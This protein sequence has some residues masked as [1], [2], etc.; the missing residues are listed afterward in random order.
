M[1]T[2]SAWLHGIRGLALLIVIAGHLPGIH[3]NL[4]PKL[5]LLGTSKTGVWLFFVLSAY[6]LSRPLA[7]EMMLTGRQAVSAFF[8]RRAFRILPL[9]FVVLFYLV[10]SEQMPAGSA[11]LHVAFVKGDFAFWTM[12]V[13]MAFYCLLPAFATIASLRA[14]LALLVLSVAIF[15]AS[16]P[17]ALAENSIFVVHYLVFFALGITVAYLP[18][19]RN[20]TAIAIGGL[21]IMA[22]TNVKV[23]SMTG[24]P[25]PIAF[26]PING[27]GCALLLYGATNSA[28]LQ[29][30]FSVTALAWL[31]RVSF[32]AY[33]MHYHI[34]FALEDIPVHPALKGLVVLAVVVAAATAAHFSVE[35]PMND[36]GHWLARRTQQR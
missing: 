15:L 28:V 5:D 2:E 35:R 10:Q 19:P 34:L 21:C 27:A 3:T 26:A 29:S 25:S 16:G 36:L 13:E 7:S 33:L 12:P 20:G 17:V 22:L 8:I 6:L 14:A 30:I 9:Y 24:L 23:L 11:W 32:G 18:K 31:G 1:S 4:I